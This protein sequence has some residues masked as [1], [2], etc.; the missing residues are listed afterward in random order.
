MKVIWTSKNVRNDSYITTP[1]SK[2]ISM[3]LGNKIDLLVFSDSD[4]PIDTVSRVLLS[5]SVVS[6]VYINEKPLPEISTIVLGK[7]GRVIQ[8][9]FFLEN[10]E[11]IDTLESDAIG[12]EL[13]LFDDIGDLNVIKNFQEQIQNG[14]SDFSKKYLELVVNS[15][16]QLA[17]G[18]YEVT[19]QKR[20]LLEA[21]VMIM[22]K[23]QHQFNRLSMLREE[24]KEA[25]LKK[26]ETN[27]S[28][29]KY[30]MTTVPSTQ[31]IFTFPEVVYKKQSK[32]IVIKEVGNVPYLT[33]FLM[34]LVDY[35]ARVE[36]KK[37]RLTVILPP[38]DSFETL[39][40]NVNDKTRKFINFSNEN[41]TPN[42]SKNVT[43][44]FT[45]YPTQT[46][47]DRL[48]TSDFNLNIILDRRTSSSKPYYRKS[49]RFPLNTF[50]AVQSE[51][52]FEA[53]KPTT[54]GM[55][56][57]NSFSSIQEVAG[58]LFTIPMFD[59]YARGRNHRIETYRQACKSF[60]DKLLEDK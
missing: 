49:D 27:I 23:L 60:Y 36:F 25:L 32:G 26:L 50:Y 58:T 39:Y 21:G 52:V 42:Y 19:E 54:P 55:R 46:V 1:T 31:G 38:G 29:S 57:N 22:E 11:L 45:N 56:K 20:Q 40:T 7:G 24:E 47:M 15:S 37:V 53:F 9:E 8:D 30:G 14:N 16:E 35:V 44:A 2:D 33:S 59:D 51:S 18:I 43:V 4:E 48:V 34:G 13:D 3:M 10:L 6:I 12:S 28:K 5:S 17:R 41:Q